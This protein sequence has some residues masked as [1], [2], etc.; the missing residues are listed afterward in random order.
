MA[1]RVITSKL[2]MH[3]ADVKVFP[4]SRPC[5]LVLDPMRGPHGYSSVAGEPAPFGASRQPDRARSV[6]TDRLGIEPDRGPFAAHGGS[7]PVGRAGPAGLVRCGQRQG[8]AAAAQTL[9]GEVVLQRD[10]AAVLQLDRR[11]ERLEARW[12]DL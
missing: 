1:S 9:A 2:L 4:A 7:E 6:D 5:F 8:L 10:L 12:P 11:V 3:P